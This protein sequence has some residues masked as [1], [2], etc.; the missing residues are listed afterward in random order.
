MYDSKYVDLLFVG[1][2][3]AC[4]LNTGQILFF[5]PTTLEILSPSPFFDTKGTINY[6]NFSEDSKNMATAV[7]QIQC[8][9]IYFTNRF[10]KKQ[11]N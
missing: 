1:M 7:R 2:H 5:D 11:L 10:R 3:L 6:I 4:G 9:Q 8:K